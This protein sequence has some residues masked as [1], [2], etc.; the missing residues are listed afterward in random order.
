MQIGER[1]TQKND[2]GKIELHCFLRRGFSEKTTAAYAFDDGLGFGYQKGER[3]T[4]T[5]T[6]AVKGDTLVLTVDGYAPGHRPLSVQV[7]AYDRFK[8]VDL[9]HRSR[10]A[11]FA[12]K[13]ARLTLTGRS[14]RTQTTALISLD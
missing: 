3:T 8:R 5:F 1:T 7:V 9:V 10:R 2:L 14:L 4:A 6:A 13:P 12:L 11:Q